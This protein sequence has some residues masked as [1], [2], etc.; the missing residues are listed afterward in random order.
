[1][2]KR[3]IGLMMFG[4]FVLS[5]CASNIEYS[6]YRKIEK[7]ENEVR[8]LTYNILCGGFPRKQVKWED[9]AKPLGFATKTSDRTDD[10]ITM[11]KE[12]DADIVFLQE[13]TQW[14]DNNNETLEHYKKELGMYGVI[15]S[16]HNR[17]RVAMLSKY[18]L[19]NVR[20]L[21]DTQNFYHNILFAEVIL[22]SGEKL[23]LATLHFGWWGNPEYRNA[24][25]AVKAKLYAAQREKLLKI[26]SKAKCSTVFAGDFNHHYNEKGHFGQSNFYNE[27]TKTGLTDSL[28]YKH[29]DYSD[30]F[31]AHNATPRVGPIDYIFVT[32]D[33]KDKITNVGIDYSKEAFEASDHLP[34]W[35]DLKF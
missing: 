13:C 17:F 31:S 8:L 27:I 15:S 12:L 6:N 35:V 16:D 19:K 29:S 30:V 22:D 34:V 28:F 7:S 3:I 4:V 14:A 1:M 23:N 10:L 25:D 18:P 9:K 33:L 32:E 11:I 24:D 2:L 20:W 5:G 26:M 21:D